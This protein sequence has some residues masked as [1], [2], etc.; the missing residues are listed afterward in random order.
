MHF[1]T[2]LFILGMTIIQPTGC[3]DD[4]YA[5]TING[6][7]TYGLSDKLVLLRGYTKMAF[8]IEALALRLPCISAP[9]LFICE[10]LGPDLDTVGPLNRTPVQATGGAAP[11]PSSP[12]DYKTA[13]KNGQALPPNAHRSPPLD[14]SKR[15]PDPTK[16]LSKRMLL[17]ALD[18]LVINVLID[19][20]VTEN[21][22]PC[23]LFYLQDNCK[24]TS[25]PYSHSYILQEDDYEELRVNAKKSACPLMI[26]CRSI[27]PDGLLKLLI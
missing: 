2:Y 1:N 5:T 19:V 14:P 24:R 6:I 18:F 13:V 15:L 25:C 16:P 4:S 27:S 10:K 21:P 7:V 3:H 20:W 17:T 26:A 9:D 12:L 22:P 23:N 11:R 8:G